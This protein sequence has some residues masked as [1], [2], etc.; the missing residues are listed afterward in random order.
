MGG[1]LLFRGLTNGIMS[2][3][4]V[5]TTFIEYV[6]DNVPADGKHE[7]ST[8]KPLSQSAATNFISLL[9]G[10]FEALF[11]RGGDFALDLARKLSRRLLAHGVSGEW[12][13][14]NWKVIYKTLELQV[15]DR[16]EKFKWLTL[17]RAINDIDISYLHMTRVA[18]SVKTLREK[19]AIIQLW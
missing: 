5:L 8:R 7:E 10:S 11:A 14:T 18:T 4:E 16:D 15:Q 3:A 17:S 13:K 9:H 2:I 12:Q 19:T 1:P 6:Y